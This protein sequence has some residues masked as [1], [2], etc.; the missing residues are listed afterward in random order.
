MVEYWGVKM[1]IV[2]KSNWN[3]NCYVVESSDVDMGSLFFYL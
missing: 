2:S 3:S 1:G